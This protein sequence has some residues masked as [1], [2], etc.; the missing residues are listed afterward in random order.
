[1][2]LVMDATWIMLTW[3][4]VVPDVCAEFGVEQFKQRGSGVFRFKPPFRILETVDSIGY[5]SH[6]IAEKT[7]IAVVQ[8]IKNEVENI[9]HGHVEDNI[10]SCLYA[11]EQKWTT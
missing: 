2:R 8:S 6:E 11:P 1:M 4:T 9:V 10:A 3:I 5:V 7:M